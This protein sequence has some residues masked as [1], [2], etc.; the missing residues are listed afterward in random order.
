MSASLKAKCKGKTVAGKQCSRIVECS[1]G[2]YCWQHQS[3]TA[4]AVAKPVAVSNLNKYPYE[5]TSAELGK[6]SAYV[7]PPESKFTMESFTGTYTFTGLA[8]DKTKPV[9]MFVDN[10]GNPLQSIEVN[11]QTIP[12]EKYI[13]IGFIKDNI[14]IRA[15][16]LDE[17]VGINYP[18][19]FEIKPHDADGYH[20]I[21]EYYAQEQ[22]EDYPDAEFSYVAHAE[23]TLTIGPKYNLINLTMEGGGG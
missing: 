15:W 6:M 1:Q 12:I 14:K 17:D 5:V 4:T 18:F 23:T 22:Q 21:D 16:V 7:K 2:Q 9:I 10:K 13:N 3:K 11:G 20:E 8:I 19:T